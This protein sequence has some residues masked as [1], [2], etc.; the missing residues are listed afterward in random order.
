MITNI[1]IFYVSLIIS[2][3]MEKITKDVVN[4]TT[5]KKYV[6]PSFEVINLEDTPKLLA[7]S[8]SAGASGSASQYRSLG[9]GSWDN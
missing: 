3:T 5:K 8:G 9:A 1:M 6:K 4:V 2:Y 7:G